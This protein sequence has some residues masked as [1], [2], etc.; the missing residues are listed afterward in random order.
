MNKSINEILRE[1]R[2]KRRKTLQIKNVQN[3]ND[4]EMKKYDGNQKK[5]KNFQNEQR[6]N[7]RFDENNKNKQNNFKNRR[8][9]FY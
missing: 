7:R 9:Y 8:V 4:V 1:S 2:E 5:D 3:S 6:I